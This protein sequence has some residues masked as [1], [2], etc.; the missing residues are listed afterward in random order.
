ME[1]QYEQFVKHFRDMLITG[2]GYTEDKVYVKSGKDTVDEDRMFVEFSRRGGIC[3]VCALHT[4]ELFD[5]YCEGTPIE[6]IVRNSVD[7]IELVKKD[8]LFEKALLME[9]YKEVK[10]D[11]FIRLLNWENNKYE[12]KDAVYR[13]LGDIAMVLYLRVSE[14]DDCLTSLKVKKHLL[15]DWNLKEKEVF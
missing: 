4:K 13:R 2:T 3:Q 12:L 8:G 11:L 1:N 15:Q 14:I 9:E 5:L 6:E 10:D 7:G